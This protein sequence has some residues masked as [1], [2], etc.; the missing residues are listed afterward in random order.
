MISLVRPT[1]VEVLSGHPIY[2]ELHRVDGTSEPGA[3]VKI[4][5][6]RERVQFERRGD[7]EA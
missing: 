5:A 3:L 6:I 1:P 2:L 7:V 4:G